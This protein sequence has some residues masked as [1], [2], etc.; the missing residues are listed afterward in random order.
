M[1]TAVSVDSPAQQTSPRVFEDGHGGRIIILEEGSATR[2][3]RF[4]T[5]M[6]RGV[7][8]PP[9]RHPNQREEFRVISGTLDLGMVNGKH[10][11]LR[12]GETLTLPAATFHRPG[13]R[14]DEPV[15]VEATLTP[16][17]RSARMFE[18]IYRV[19]REHRG[20]GMALRMALVFDR[21]RQEIE[22]PLP[23]LAALRAM[24]RIA[25]FAGIRVE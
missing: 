8:P 1:S 19:L 2:P 18:S 22:F 23:V 9:E 6:T 24:A 12:A 20:L 16:G 3:M 11:E 5:F 7:S 14:F 13:N 10:V 17:L 25:R 21:H 4:R 15:E